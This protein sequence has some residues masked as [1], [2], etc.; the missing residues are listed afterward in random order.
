MKKQ[1]KVPLRSEIE[2]ISE[3]VNETFGVTDTKVYVTQTKKKVSKPD[4]V[5]V[6]QAMAK[7]AAQYLT[8]SASRILHYFY[9]DTA[10]ENYLSIDIK[11]ISETLILS[12]RQVIRA[13]N[14][15]EA[16]N[17]VVK[18]INLKDRRRHDYFLNPVVAWR[19]DGAVRNKAIKTMVKSQPSQLNLFNQSPQLALVQS[20]FSKGLGEEFPNEPSAKH[21]DDT[22]S[23]NELL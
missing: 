10:Y 3:K 16:F 22:I 23:P 9:G 6:F 8:G 17:V 4:F 11:T 12:E 7:M 5:M 21:T 20:E 15:L 13:L 19:G 18:H 1:Q 2:A 14:E